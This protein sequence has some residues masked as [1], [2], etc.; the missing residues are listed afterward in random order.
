MAIYT[1]ILCLTVTL[2][3]QPPVDDIQN[4]T[5]Y[6]IAQLPI[7]DHNYHNI[8]R[9]QP[10]QLPAKTAHNCH[11]QTSITLVQKRSTSVES[12]LTMFSLETAS[13]I[14]AVWVDAASSQSSSSFLSGT[15]GHQMMRWHDDS[16]GM[17]SGTGRVI[18]RTISNLGAC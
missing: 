4:T 7:H 14:S 10:L 12:H 3:T 6:S 2:V 9:K 17:A 16:D 5:I 13:I 18:R 8:H 15:K 11:S 1:A